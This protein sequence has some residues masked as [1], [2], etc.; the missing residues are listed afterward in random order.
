MEISGAQI[1]AILLLRGHLTTCGDVSGHHNS[2]VLLA[3]NGQK[4]TMLCSILQCTTK[5]CPTQNINGAE[6]EKLWS[7]AWPTT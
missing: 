6:V 3:S 1:G 4:P 7:S 2:E 5:N